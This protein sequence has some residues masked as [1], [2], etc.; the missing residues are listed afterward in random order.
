MKQGLESSTSIDRSTKP[1]VTLA[2]RTEVQ[3]R[4]WLWIILAVS[5]LV[6]VLAAFYLGDRVEDMPG[7]Q[8]Q[9]SYDALARSVMA[10]KGFTFDKGWY[11][12]T[13]AH[14]PTAHWSFLYPLYLAGVY[15]LFGYHPLVARLIQ[16]IVGG[17]LVCCMVYR[18]G[19]RLFGPRV[20]LVGAGLTAIYAYFV[21]FSVALMTET[22]Y[23]VAVLFA[24][25][26]AMEL[27]ERPALRW[28]T[29]LGLTLGIAAL[30][31]QVILLFVPV[32]LLWCVW[33]GR[34]K[35]RL[36]ELGVPVVVIATLI[37]PWTVRN[38]LVYQHFLPLNSNAGFA[39]YSANHPNHGTNW[40]PTYVAPIPA[41]LH[42]L[43]EAELND[44]L[45]REGL[46]FVVEDP[47]R[48]LLLSLSRVE[49]YFWFLPSAES[50][51]ISNISRM[52]SFGI[53]LPF[54]LCGLVL[55]RHQWHRCLLLYLFAGIY[56]V[57]H[58][59]SWPAPRYRLPMDAVLIIFAALAIVKLA[60]RV[61]KGRGLA[62][63][64]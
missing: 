5:V 54:M 51:T 36:R 1:P 41:E 43:N 49:E 7:A 9:I 38:Y 17:A 8:D 14:T 23:I 18:I 29:L 32:L 24:L 4:R 3:A 44:A 13:P 45:M 25:D 52:L 37:I 11:P 33:A 58:L 55:S 53:C 2:A 60:E 12:F 48:Y 21:Y 64:R 31:R 39:F 63:E 61:V 26:T 20:G 28:W 40:Q 22:F 59:L 16:G 47:W 10:G 27:V 62:R 6:R 42:S 56:T 46:R 19:R 50:S 15:L 34:Q 57:I 30:F 35:I